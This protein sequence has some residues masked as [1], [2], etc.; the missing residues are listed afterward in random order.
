MKYVLVFA[1][2]IVVQDLTVKN[3][4]PTKAAGRSTDD[5]LVDSW[6]YPICV[7]IVKCKGGTFGA[8]LNKKTC[9]CYGCRVDPP[10]KPFTPDF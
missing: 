1:L 4:F 3:V 6:C 8:K 7:K 5:E 9:T 10:F 2:L